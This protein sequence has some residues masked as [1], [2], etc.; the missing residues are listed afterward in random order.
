[1]KTD[2]VKYTRHIYKLEPNDCKYLEYS[3]QIRANG[4]ISLPDII[5][6]EKSRDF[7]NGTGFTEFF[8]LIDKPLIK[9]CDTKTG[10]RSTIKENCFYGDLVQTNTRGEIVN[11]FL[12]VQ[13]VD[14]R[15]TM[16]VDYFRGYKP[17][18][19]TIRN[20]VIVKHQFQ[21]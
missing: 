17:F 3:L 18:N 21:Y 20:E 2:N 16:I 15:K 9:D 19:A 14:D 4:K 12:L 7:H 1:M 13:F 11:S 6:I 5:R 8:R 10:M